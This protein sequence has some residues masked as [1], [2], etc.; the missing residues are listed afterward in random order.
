LNSSYKSGHT[1]HT[2]SPELDTVSYD[3]E[4]WM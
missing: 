1:V 2:F 3:K 4:W